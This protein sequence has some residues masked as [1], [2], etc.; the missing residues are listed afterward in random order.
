MIC[1]FWPEFGLKPRYVALH[2]TEN[3][4]VLKSLFT[5]SIR[6][7]IVSVYCTLGYKASVERRSR[8]KG[9]NDVLK[10]LF[11][12]PL[13]V[14]QNSVVLTQIAVKISRPRLKECADH[15]IQQYYNQ[16]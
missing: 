14:M 11:R 2:V 10:K 9:G 8:M 6:D 4:K 1:I 7:H 5:P 3:E 12:F 16:N 15:K 13:H